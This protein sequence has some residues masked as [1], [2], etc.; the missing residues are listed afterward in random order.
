MENETIPTKFFNY[1]LYK[2]R[3]Q[4][5]EKTT[6]DILRLI[7]NKVPRELLIEELIRKKIIMRDWEQK[8]NKYKLRKNE[9]KQMFY[10]WQNNK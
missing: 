6:K 7:I 9:K 5:Y 8:G 4:L 3:L 2:S 10:M 1:D